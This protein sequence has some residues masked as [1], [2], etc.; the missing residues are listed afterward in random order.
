MSRAA[1]MVAFVV[2]GGCTMP[3]SARPLAPGRTQVAVGW[4]TL[5]HPQLEDDADLASGQ[6]MVR[7]GIAARTDAAIVLSRLPSQS[8]ST[9]MAMLEAKV[10]LTPAEGP[11]TV[12]LAVGTGVVWTDDAWDFD[13]EAVVV[14]PTLYVGYDLSP[15]AEIVIT[16]RGY[17]AAI[18]DDNQHRE[19]NGGASI[20]A[21]F[22]DRARTFALQP[23]LTVIG[24]DRE[25]YVTVGVAMSVGN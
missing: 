10:R 5:A 20:G 22:T 1:L 4:A 13:R 21:R 25:T 7:R 3:Q 14:T 16:A 15:T 19:L 8:A 11:L 17:L 18:D 23:Q 12:S 9:S 24:A 2:G 6:V